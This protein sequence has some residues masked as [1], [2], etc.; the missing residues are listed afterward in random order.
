MQMAAARQNATSDC[1]YGL[2]DGSGTILE[3]REGRT[4]ARQ[5]KCMVD[6]IQQSRLSFADIPSEFAGLK[7]NDFSTDIY[8]ANKDRRLAL[9]AKKVVIGYVKNYAAMAEMGKGLYFYSNTKGSGKTRLAVSLGNALINKYGAVV[10]Y[11]TTIRLLNEIRDTFEVKTSKTQAELIADTVASQVL[12]IDD[13]G[14]EKPTPWAEEILYTILNERMISKKITIFT[15][16]LSSDE[17]RLDE[18]IRDRVKRM[19]MPVVCP[20]ESVRQILA[21]RENDLVMKKLLG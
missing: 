4:Y 14:I 1:P 15:S 8:T 12:I 11:T 3:C 10:K 13:I 6:R 9:N 5:C 17:L 16:N 20:E 19:A 7:V 18:R 2:C 21:C